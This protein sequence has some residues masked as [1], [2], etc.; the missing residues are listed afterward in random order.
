MQEPQVVV[1]V[2]K[3]DLDARILEQPAELWQR[4]G[5]ERIDDRALRA[6]RQLQQV[7]A[8]DESVKAR[9]FRIERENLR[10]RD[11]AEEARGVGGGI[12]IGGGCVGRDVHEDGENG[13]AREPRVPGGRLRSGP[14]WTQFSV[15]APALRSSPP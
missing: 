12:E 4:S 2:V 15:R 6:G 8:I 13:C 3:D 9:P 10:A 11:R 1:G 14:R 7:D 5:G